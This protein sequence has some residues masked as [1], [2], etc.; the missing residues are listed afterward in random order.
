MSNVTTGLYNTAIGLEAGAANGALSN[1]TAVGAD[2]AAGQNNTL[3]LGNTNSTPG[4]AFVNV[5]IGTETPRSIFEASLS[6]ATPSGR[7]SPLPIPSA[8][9]VLESRPSTSTPTCPALPEPTIP[10]AASKRSATA[11]VATA[12][13]FFPTTTLPGSGGPNAG[14]V[15]NM[16][17]GS[18]GRVSIGSS[19]PDANDFLAQLVVD[20]I[21]PQGSDEAA[22]ISANGGTNNEGN[23]T[24]GI[25][26][27][28][29]SSN[30]GSSTAS[31]GLGGSF[32]GGTNF[33]MAEGNDGTP[34]DG[35][36]AQNGYAFDGYNGFAGD[37]NGNVTI[38]GKL[39]ADAKNFRIDHPL[40][41]ANK[42]LVHASVE[43]SEMM[44]IY[45]G[46]VTTDELGIATI[47]LPDWFESLNTD[48]RYQLTTIGRDAHAWIRRRSPNKQFKIATNATNVKVSWQ[49]TAVRQDAYAM[50]HPLVVEE[51]K[52]TRE[53]GFYQHPELY[54][55]PA[56][57]QTEWGRHPG[58]MQRL[59]TRQE[60]GKAAALRAKAPGANLRHDQPASAVDR[61]FASPTVVKPQHPVGAQTSVPTL[62]PQT[63]SAR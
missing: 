36:Y 10:A 16:N 44:N 12:S 35:I 51:E 14:L 50:A 57:K 6:A 13:G 30:G 52:P 27:F 32:V 43:S 21:S 5:G 24:D 4:S 33:G 17:I 3:I 63:A 62:N 9:A 25:D 39:F 46:N 48:F 8:M 34:G 29:G 31:A 11:T 38:A 45:T 61:K 47:T 53:R 37:F 26:G 15:L 20:S 42:Y 18:N 1:T 41:P 2:A 60:A 54:G 19:D 28:G 40:D 22:A 59:K 23:G 58:M 49:V 7:P 56:E 55:Q